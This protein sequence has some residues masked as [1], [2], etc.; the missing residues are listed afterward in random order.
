MQMTE[1]PKTNPAVK[2]PAPAPARTG[3][4]ATPWADRTTKRWWLHLEEA[5]LDEGERRRRIWN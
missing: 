4:D 5:D 1:N 2:T 3:D